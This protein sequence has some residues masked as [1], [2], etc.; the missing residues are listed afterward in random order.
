MQWRRL[1]LQEVRQVGDERA[2][3]DWTRILAALIAI[4]LAFGYLLLVSG[5]AGPR[6]STLSSSST[7]EGSTRSIQIP[8][9]VYHYVDFSPVPGS[10]GKQLTVSPG[11]FLGEMDFLIAAGYH[12]VTLDQGYR[13]LGGLSELPSKPVIVTFDDGGLGDYTIAY[14]ILRDKGLTATFFVVTDFVGTPRHASWPQLGEMAK[15]GM[16]IES[17]T[18]HHLDLTTL[19]DAQLAEELGSS[20]SAIQQHLGASVRFLA[21]PGGKFNSRVEA[22][23]RVAGYV[24]CVTVVPGTTLSLDGVYRWPRIGVSRWETLASFRKALGP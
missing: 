13:A 12:T 8:I 21:Y 22:A 4:L 11:Q 16:S 17:H 6:V 5:C 19:S 23:A 18:A 10:W 15:A 24:A 3:T 14:R 7:V 20:R 2:L 1:L 9:L